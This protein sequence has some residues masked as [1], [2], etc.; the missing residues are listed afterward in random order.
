[1]W[2]PETKWPEEQRDYRRALA[3]AACQTEFF[4]PRR[5]LHVTRAPGRL[6]VMGGIA[7]YSGAL[8]LEMPI[9]AA[10]WVAAQPSD[11][12]EVVI[13]SGDIRALGGEATVRIP[14]AEIVPERPLTYERAH[15]LL[16]GDPRR[17]WA[18]Y[19]AGA[20]VVLHAEL[21][22]PL[23]H[24][25]R[26]LV[27]SEVPVGKG[28]SS[29]AA[30]EVATLEAVAP[31]VGAT[32][33]DREIA[34]LAQKVENFVVGA[35]CGV[36]DQMTSALGRRDH[37]LELV[38]QPAEVIGQLR[39]PRR[40]R[41]LRR[42]LGDSPRR[43][44]RRL[45]NGPRRGVHGLPHDHRRRGRSGPAAVTGA[46]R[47]RRRDVQG[48]PG[49]RPRRRLARPLS[50]GRS[51]SSCWEA[52]SSRA[53]RGRPILRPTIDP[54]RSYPVRAATAHAIEEHQRVHEFR[55]LLTDKRRVDEQTR[56]RL[57]ELMYASHAS[58]SACGLGSD[59]TDHLVALV[60]EAG[61]RL[62]LYGAKI[63]GGGSG[64]TVAVLAERG[65]QRAVSQIADL[66]ELE[67]G[68]GSAVYVGSSDGSR[69]FGVRTLT[70]VR[71]P[72]T[73]I[74]RRVFVM[75]TRNVGNAN[76]RSSRS[77]ASVAGAARSPRA[78]RMLRRRHVPPSTVC[79]GVTPRRPASGRGAT[80]G[81]CDIYAED[82]GPCVAAHSTV[83]ALY[84]G[85][86]GPLY[87]VKKA[88]GTTMDIGVA[89]GGRP[90]KRG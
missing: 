14:L 4:D 33:N 68:H 57:G 17:A 56:V 44:R 83:R 89:R 38:C 2:M 74:K 5:P 71:A 59:G 73:L 82:G 77:S 27:W 16:T 72:Q 15:A 52:T 46:R 19:A 58:Y 13:E 34:L 47:D 43:L 26:L 12:P 87:Q 3:W 22:K 63:T 37:L 53:S 21:G 25:L 51:P 62:G 6:D 42:R 67:S 70:C 84:G 66:Y 28:L 79:E 65:A 35:P 31:L 18:A 60:R 64:G 20:L 69:A 48:I 76:C 7:D 41:V 54:A 9:A 78:R 55:A 81:P 40:H 11:E 39:G 75:R 85:Y 49:Q 61:P 86:S 24:G 36:M 29:S 10:T 80:K 90:R 23:R 1:M 32:L 8:V 88:D 50:R 30:L 45:R